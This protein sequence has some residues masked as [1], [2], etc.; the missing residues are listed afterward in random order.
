MIGHGSDLRIETGGQ[1]TGTCTGDIT[2]YV[3]ETAVFNGSQVGHLTANGVISVTEGNTYLGVSQ[4]QPISGTGRLL[5]TG[6]ATTSFTSSPSGELRF[7]LPRFDSQQ[8]PTNVTFNDSS[9]AAANIIPADRIQ[10]F[11]V[12]GEGPYS[13]PYSFYVDPPATLFIP[14]ATR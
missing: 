12:F 2:L 10:G 1:N 6:V 9:F 7:Y 11:F 3:G 8:I 5:V 14:F 13:S 4:N